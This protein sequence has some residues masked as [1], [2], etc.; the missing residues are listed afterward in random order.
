M[1]GRGAMWHSVMLLVAAALPCCFGGEETRQVEGWWKDVSGRVLVEM[2]CP[3]F[4]LDTPA[5]WTV[6]GGP[7]AVTEDKWDANEDIP[8]A[9]PEPERPAPGGRRKVLQAARDVELT[10]G[11]AE[12]G[13]YAVTAEVMAGPTGRPVTLAAAVLL[14]AGRTQPGYQVELR[15]N[16]G[17]TVELWM[18]ASERSGDL[19]TDVRGEKKSKRWLP[20]RLVP[21]QRLAGEVSEAQRTRAAAEY[22]RDCETTTPW[23]QQ[24]FRLRV[25]VTPCQARMW[26]NGVLVASVDWPQWTKG[27]IALHLNTG[28]RVRSLRVEG[29]PPSSDGYLP[30]DLTSRHNG[31]GLDKGDLGD[32]A[33]FDSSALPKA[34][35][36]VEVGGVPFCWNAAPGKPNHVDLGK[37]KGLGAYIL[38]DAASGD[39]RMRLRVPKRQYRQLAIVA[40]SDTR[41]GGT[42]N[43]LNVRMFKAGHAALLDCCWPVPR[44]DDTAPKD[45]AQR[46]AAGR[47]C[48]KDGKAAGEG[49]L[50]FIRIPLDPGA[51][52]DFLGSD[53]EIALE[54]EFTGPP[55]RE[56]YPEIAVPNPAI[57]IFAA[58]LVESPV[59]MYVRSAEVGHVFVEPKVPEFIVHLRN[60]TATPQSGRL[61]LTETDFYGQSEVQLVPVSLEAKQAV[62]PAVPLPV[63]RRGIH[64][65]DAKLISSSGE[66]M[67]RR[68]TTCAVLPPDTRQADRDSPF[69][70]WVFIRDHYGAGWD[71]AAPLMNK[72][73]VRW[74][75]TDKAQWQQGFCDRYKLHRNYLILM[76]KED[77][78]P[79]QVVEY[80]KA[81]PHN[82]H[83]GVFG[84]TALSDRHYGYFPP[85]L[86]ENPKPRDLTP[87]EEATFK[88]LFDRGVA[89]SEAVRRECPDAKLIFGNGYPHFIHTFMS[90]KFP[91]NLVDGFALDFMGDQIY[92]FHSLKEVAKH[93]GYG[94]VPFYITEGF[95]VTS[96]CGYYPDR[97][98]EDRQSNTYISGMLRGFALGIEKYLGACELWDNGGYYY[99]T[100]YGPVSLCRRAPELNP[101]PGYCAYGTMTLMLDQ[102]KF[103]SRIPTGS[104]NAFLLRFDGPRGPIYATWAVSGRRTLSLRPAAGASPRLTDSQCN[105]QP[106]AVKDGRVSLEIDSAPVWLDGAGVVADAQ[107]GTPVYDS[108]PPPG[109]SVLHS[110][111]AVDDFTQ[112]SGPYA[113]LEALNDETP[114]KPVSF[115]LSLGAGQKTGTKALAIALKEEAGVSPYRLRYAV[116]RP[117][118]EITIP[119]GATELGLWI[120]GN[121]A[122][123]VDLELRDAKGERWTSVRGARGFC[124]GTPYG[125]WNAFDGWQYVRWPLP[126]ASGRPAKDRAELAQARPPWAKW[127]HT[128][129][130]GRLDAPAK[131]SGIILEQYGKVVYISELVPADSPTWL[132]GDVLVVAGPKPPGP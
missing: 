85:E 47:M 79:G 129:G 48:R 33:A 66:L 55:V 10:A 83:W 25:E 107:V 116:L 81:N 111:S 69:G 86:L 44:W 122:A 39:R 110:V 61:E 1:L 24:W 90:R 18:S 34:G 28:D 7:L 31:D 65:L 93:Y 6:K 21:N 131:L 60:A 62:S 117:R 42:S 14:E 20:L 112:D 100:G 64:Y 99:Y 120:C 32:G 97:K 9:A 27:G 45:G 53:E 56:G 13:R 80:V 87:D 125:G 54:L 127:R 12:W 41:S 67:V 3:D 113:E 17:S 52:Q 75:F 11:N 70:M 84:E 88:R 108:A 91:R 89:C 4:E 30:L 46:L 96:A 57:H 101:K 104:V 109:A 26:V 123:W 114:V 50:W 106:L 73:G 23:S 76:Q 77:A 43:V 98:S 49:S 103:H 92:M 82:R 130:D 105:S 36:F 22:R 119:E 59:E 74:T 71:S 5:P 63:Q 115:E 2:N 40:A 29:L 95:Y 118:Q 132:L 58:T 68:Q 15:G 72:I 51:F 35:R 126:G 102:A 128:G 124:C 121:G 78:T 16:K 8:K 38:C 19:L 37:I 94:D